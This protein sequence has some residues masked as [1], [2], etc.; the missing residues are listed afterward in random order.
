MSAFQPESRPGTELPVGKA[1][2]RAAAVWIFYCGPG[3]EGVFKEKIVF[4][5]AGRPG[6]RRLYGEEALRFNNCRHTIRGVKNV[7]Q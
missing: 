3:V 4:S 6:A 5:R 2:R 7:Q 1:R